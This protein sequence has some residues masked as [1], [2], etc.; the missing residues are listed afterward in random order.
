MSSPREAIQNSV[1]HTRAGNGIV[2]QDLNQ[3]G[4]DA[5]FPPLNLSQSKKYCKT[6]ADRHYE[7][8]SIASLLVPRSIRQ[9]FFN[10]YAFCR[11]SDDLADELGDSAKS[12]RY[13]GW[14]QHQLQEC[15]HGRASHPVYRALQE[16]IRIHGLPIKPFQD[17]L[18]AFVQDQHTTRYST[19]QDLLGYC[20]GSANPI[21]RILLQF[22]KVESDHA[23]QLS[24]Q[25]CTGL[26]I[27]NFC[28]DIRQDAM[29]GRIYLPKERW[30]QYPITENEILTGNVSCNLVHAMQDWV[31]TAQSHLIAGLPLVKHVPRWLARDIQLFARG[32]LTVLE[33]ISSVGFD[34]W[35]Q[36]IEVTRKQKVRLLLQAILRPRSLELTGFKKLDGPI[37]V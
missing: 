12:L 33:N 21:G 2:L 3:F 26:Q 9:D 32:G 30:A 10:V 13:L 7:N 20:R 8:F 4:P 11:W 37:L 36:P 14:W 24:D 25:I 28:Q 17:L 5:N 6:L 19:D 34:V 27:A 35:T 15:F 16:S 29:R 18:E 22:G 31:S 23:K 1:S